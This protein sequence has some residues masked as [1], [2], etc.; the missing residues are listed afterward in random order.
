VPRRPPQPPLEVLKAVG[1]DGGDNGLR[2]TLQPI[3]YH[4]ASSFWNAAS[5]VPRLA[6]YYAVSVVLLE[7]EKPSSMTGRVYQYGIQTFVG[8]SPRLDASQ[9]TIDVNVPGMA[10]QSLVATPAEVP[11][12]R[13]VTFTGFN[14]PATPPGCSSRTF[15]GAITSGWI[16]PGRIATD[17]RVYATVQ[18]EADGA[19]APGVYAARS[20]RAPADH[21]RHHGTSASPRTRPFSI[22]ARIDNLTFAADI[23]TLT[24]F[25]FAEPDA[26]QPP[27]PPDAIRSRSVTPS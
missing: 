21:G 7:P 4:E 25:A 19:V 9:N 3:A 12:G 16:P 10:P 13:Q 1:L 11:F 17:D 22:A 2:I 6:L 14:R 15:A 27:F 20:G 8:G 18:E 26:S 23:G 24:G 5:L